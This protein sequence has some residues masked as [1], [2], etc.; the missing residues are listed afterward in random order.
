MRMGLSTPATPF[1]LSISGLSSA[2]GFPFSF[3]V[4]VH[5][6]HLFHLSQFCG[7]CNIS[8]TPNDIFTPN[9]HLRCWE[10]NQLITAVSHLHAGH[11]LNILWNCLET[12]V[13]FSHSVISCFAHKGISFSL[14]FCCIT[15][16]PPGFPSSVL[17]HGQHQAGNWELLLWN[18]AAQSEVTQCHNCFYNYTPEEELSILWRHKRFQVRYL[19]SGYANV[20]AVGPFCEHSQG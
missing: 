18:T 10:Q 5:C 8:I 11:L 20:I 7:A 2:F 3:W 19:N 17:S 16:Q 12:V 4:S 9:D 1:P 13:V 6:C 14:K 15:Q